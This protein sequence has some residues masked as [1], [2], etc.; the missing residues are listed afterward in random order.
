MRQDAP[1]RIFIIVS[2]FIHI[3]VLCPWPFLR[4]M[5]RPEVSFRKI[6]LTYFQDSERD[7]VFIKDSASLTSYLGEFKSPGDSAVID[8]IR[9]NT[10]LTLNIEIG[11]RP[12]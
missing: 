4:M 9:G 11:K 3:T 6:E 5:P 10:S 2:A 12:E 1:L 8:L 7:D